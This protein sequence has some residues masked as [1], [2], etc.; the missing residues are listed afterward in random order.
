MKPSTSQDTS[1]T[2]LQMAQGPKHEAVK[3]QGSKQKMLMLARQGDLSKSWR[4]RHQGPTC[5]RE[6]VNNWPRSVGEQTGAEPGRK[7]PRTVGPSRPAQP[8]FVPVR[9]PLW[10]TCSSIYCLYLRWPPHR[11]I[12]QTAA[13]KKEKHREE[14]DDRHKSSSCLGDGLG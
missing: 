5:I 12:H 11:S 2:W 14:A 9:D 13:E 8:V 1:W 10:P 6:Q 3:L 7:G 4:R